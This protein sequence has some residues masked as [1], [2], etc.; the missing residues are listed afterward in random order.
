[1]DETAQDPTRYDHNQIELKWHERWNNDPNLYKAEID[2]AQGRRVVLKAGGKAALDLVV[3]KRGP[4]FETVYVRFPGEKAVYQIAG[5]LA[6]SADRKVDEWRDKRSN[7]ESSF[8]RK[9]HLS[10]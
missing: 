5:R 2:S 10:S 7:G 6:E 9:P 8:H 1:M 4:N 3:G